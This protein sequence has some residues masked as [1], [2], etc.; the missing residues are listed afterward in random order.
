MITRRH[1]LSTAAGSILGVPLAGHAAFGRSSWIDAHVHVWTPDRSRYP[2]AS[3]F[4]AN[5]LARPSFTPEQ[6]F[7]HSEPAG[8][9]RIVLI[10]MSYYKADNR[11]MLDMMAAHPGTFSGVAI[12][13]ENAA[14]LRV[15]MKALARQGVRG[16]RLSPKGQDIQAWL[17]SPGIEQMWRVG[18]DEGLNMCLLINPEALGPIAKMCAKFPKTPVVIDHFARVGISGTV[19]RARLD[20]LLHLSKYPN[21]TLKTSAFYALG[22]KSPPY[23]DLSPM[24]RECRDYYGAERLM[25]ASDSPFQVDPGHTY[26]DSISLIRDRL[27]FLTASDKAWM[28]R[29][30]A[31]RVFFR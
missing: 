8:V 25:W 14:D 22:K 20:R 11:Y 3:G 19:T 5:K 21:V 12:V 16:F 26:Q 7:A 4:D 6:L 18:A 13:D 24:I 29:K 9:T 30:T 28:L 17:A 1:F 27:D 15:Q 2:L 31:E 10:Q 23:L